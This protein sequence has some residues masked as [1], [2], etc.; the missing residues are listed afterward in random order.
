[1]FIKFDCSIVKYQIIITYWVFL[2]NSVYIDDHV[3]LHCQWN[4]WVV[5]Y[6]GNFKKSGQ[7]CSVSCSENGLGGILRLRQRRTYKGNAKALCLGDDYTWIQESC[8]YG[9]KCPINGG[10]TSWKQ[11][12]KCDCRNDVYY[13]F[14]ERNCQNPKPQFN[15]RPCTGES[16][17]SRNCE[18]ALGMIFRRHSE[19]I[20]TSWS[21]W[22]SCF[23][24]GSKTYR[25]RTINQC[26][27]NITDECYEKFIV[28]YKH[29]HY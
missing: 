6:G 19:H 4:E 15:G 13:S 16:T 11:V 1:M 23:C 5:E 7:S 14:S 26:R 24:N 12:K 20:S 18:C 8:N 25:E 17:A 28:F 10:W 2:K 9:V 29:F 3:K 27:R 21:Q 22:S